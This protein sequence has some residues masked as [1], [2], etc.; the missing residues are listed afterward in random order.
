[1]PPTQG[2][3][4]RFATY[5]LNENQDFSSGSKRIEILVDVEIGEKDSFRSDTTYMDEH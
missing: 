4:E 3:S 1:M 2:R 5:V